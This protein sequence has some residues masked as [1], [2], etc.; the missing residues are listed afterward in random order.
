MKKSMLMGALALM[1]AATPTMAGFVNGGFENTDLSGWSYRWGQI[2]PIHGTTGKWTPP[3]T[4][5]S[6][7]TWWGSKNWPGTADFSTTTAKLASVTA[8]EGANPH[9]PNY[10]TP[11]EGLRQLI[12]NYKPGIGDIMGDGNADVTQIKQKALVTSADMEDGK[13]TV[14]VAWGAIL[15]NPDSL[16]H[17]SAD[18]PG[19]FVKVGRKPLGGNWTYIE[20]FH[21]ADMG[22][23]NGWSR[24]VTDRGEPMWAK[25]AN[26]AVPVQLNDSVSIEMVVL[27]CSQRG[28]GAY[29]Y[30]DQVGFKKPPERPRTVGMP[31]IY[32]TDT[33]NIG[34]RVKLAGDFGSGR[35]INIDADAVD[36]GFGWSMG[37][38]YMRDR[39]KIVGDIN[40]KGNLVRQNGT[41][42]TGLIKK[43]PALNIV[44]PAVRAVVPGTADQFVYSGNLATIPPGS[45]RNIVAY[46][47]SIKL[48]AGTYNLNSFVMYSGNNVRLILDNS[49]GP[50]VVNMVS[51]FSKY[52]VRDSVVL[53][54]SDYIPNGVFFYTNGNMNI[55][56]GVNKVWGSFDAPKGTITLDSRKIGGYVHAKKVFV[57]SDAKSTCKES[58]GAL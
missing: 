42:I 53:S 2:R 34:A 52:D 48:T 58:S 4:W 17:P 1:G 50:I 3:S 47:G 40:Y 26:I 8:A 54:G 33:L 23:I 24:T 31:C 19:F 10:A 37:N 15:E 45:Y 41:S 28:H 5:E 13:Y 21:S 6:D 25:S 38:V 55:Y 51:D 39:S 27:D 32:G 9:M 36:T 46:G 20:E 18:Q 12:I 44:P 35:G 22:G 30:L 29:A 56:S 16:S 14:Y 57:N 7:M 43:D 49:A 11:L